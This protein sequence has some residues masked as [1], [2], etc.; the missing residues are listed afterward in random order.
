MKQINLM[1]PDFVVICGD[2]VDKADDK[3]FADF[4]SI[5]ADFELPCYCA[6]G[7]HD[8]QNKP[9]LES[10]R[11]YREKIGKDY[12]TIEHKGYTFVIANT[13]L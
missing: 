4:N 3:L 12:Y 13:Q 2:L 9:T 10:L 1:R 8:V 7:N 11:R 5:R 6:A